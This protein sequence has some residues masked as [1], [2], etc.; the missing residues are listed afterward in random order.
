[1][2]NI[3][4][5]INAVGFF[6]LVFWFSNFPVWKS[7]SSVLKSWF[8]MWPYSVSIRRFSSRDSLNRERNRG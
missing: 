5:G 7:V 8:S 6:I 1:M 4:D 2:N 3:S